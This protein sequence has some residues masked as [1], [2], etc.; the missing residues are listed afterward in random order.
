MFYKIKSRILNLIKW[1]PVIWYDRDW[2]YGYIY[3]F[4]YYKLR[5]MQEFFESDKTYS[6][7]ALKIAKKIMIA[8]NLAKRLYEDKYLENATFWH[9]RKFEERLV[10]EWFKPTI[11]GFYIYVEDPNTERRKSFERCCNHSDYMKKQDRE[12]LFRMLNKYIE[13]WW[14]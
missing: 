11:N 3:K 2:D 9:D 13:H 10:D 1:L 7:N 5:F 6:V 14:D 8:K 12:M 4:L